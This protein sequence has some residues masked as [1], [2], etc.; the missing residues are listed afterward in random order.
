M[1]SVPPRALGS[2][3]VIFAAASI[4]VAAAQRGAPSRA[5]DGAP[6]APVTSALRLG[7][8]PGVA[9][10]L[11]PAPPNDVPAAVAPAEAPDVPA[12]C[13]PEPAIEVRVSE[14]PPA[15]E[16]FRLAKEKPEALGSASLGSPTR[17]S[18]FGG[19][20]LKD[21]E[22]ILRAGG[23]GWGTELVIRSIERAVREVRRCFP[24]SPS[25]Y[26][27]DIARER[28]GWLKPHRSHQSGLDADIGY[29]YKTQATWYQR[30]T[31]QNL[32]AARTW[33]LVRSLIEGGN[34]EMI[35][36]DVS[37]QRL[38]QA[39]VASLPEGERPAEDVF[40]SPTKRD[41][42]IRH[43]WG[44]ATHFHVRFRDPAAVALGHR[45]AD[46]VP[47]LRGARRAPR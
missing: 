38:L 36:I 8:L 19:V 22:G 33:A 3:I 23:Y 12:R 39:H 26:V 46:I 20:E 44:H 14:P 29:Y 6:A 13:A 27:G 42:L 7:A 1:R 10:V 11:A 16:L 45:L 21:S 2:A 9:S 47:R 37:V 40:P 18:L 32:D 41:T 17:G 24:G 5:N 35:F 31:A 34:V 25:L 30:A 15:A 43:A 4:V 28:G